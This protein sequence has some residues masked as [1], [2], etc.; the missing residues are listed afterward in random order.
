MRPQEKHPSNEQPIIGTGRLDLMLN[1][2]IT[3]NVVAAVTRMQPVE[4]TQ[5]NSLVMMN[6]FHPTS[7]AQMG[8]WPYDVASLP[9]GAGVAYQ[10]G[11]Q[12][13]K[14]DP[15]TG[16]CCIQVSKA[17]GSSNS[18]FILDLKTPSKPKLVCKFNNATLG[19]ISGGVFYG[20]SKGTTN[21]FIASVVLDNI[22]ISDL[23]L[24]G[25]KPCMGEHVITNE[26]MMSGAQKGIYKY[27][28]DPCVPLQDPFDC[29]GKYVNKAIHEGNEDKLFDLLQPE[30][31]NALNKFNNNLKGKGVKAHFTST[32]RPATY[33]FHLVEYTNKKNKYQKNDTKYMA[34]CPE[35][36]KLFEP[37]GDEAKAH[38]NPIKPADPLKGRGNHA[39]G[40]AA[41]INI[42]DINDETKVLTNKSSPLK[43]WMVYESDW[44]DA[45]L[46]MPYP[47]DETSRLSR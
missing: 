41:D 7:P 18:W 29:I 22:V 45:G 38:G 44:I 17:D 46:T 36:A 20:I 5:G 3:T 4:S 25:G 10:I 33:Q 31:K 23:G 6:E 8:F 2:A 43:D 30:M 34:N 32:Y 26:E 28:S 42:V 13:P 35:L 14:I 21:Q 24:C 9:F 16:L 15:N 37:G 11:I 40:I 12:S 39:Q 47:G 27:N 1:S 19:S